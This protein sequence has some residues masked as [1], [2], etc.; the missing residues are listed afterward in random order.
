MI[1]DC[2]TLPTPLTLHADLCI[3]G[4]G[5]GG[6]M[7][8]LE[9]AQAGLKVVVLEAGSF[10]TPSGMSQLEDDMFPKLF[11]ESGGR[12]N[13]DHN[14]HIY[15][16]RGIGGSTLHNLNLIKRI[17]NPILDDWIKTRQL[18]E[19]Q[20]ED[21]D[22]LY[23]EVEQL[24]EVSDV[25]ESMIN[26]H[27][28]LLKTGNE[29]L[30][31]K[32]GFMKHNRTGCIGSGFCEVGCAYDA[33]NNACKVLVP[34]AVKAGAEFFTHCQASRV[35]HKNG[36]VTGV[37]AYVVDKDNYRPLGK[38]EVKASR[39]C[40]SAS[41]T[42]TAAI[43]KRSRLKYPK[44]SVGETLRIHPAVIV[45]GEYDQPVRA[46]EG[47]PQ[48]Y[49]CTEFL[50]FENAASGEHNKGNKANRLWIVNAF[51]HPMG[52]ST[53][54]PGHGIAHA[55]LMARYDHMAV[56]TAMLHDHSK[57]V[58]KPVKDL[59]LKIDYKL[60]HE[61]QEELHFGL[62]ACARLI[63]A[64]G[65]KRAIISTDP[66]IE[67]K[68]E[69]ELDKIDAISISKKAVDIAAVHP[70]GSVPMGDDP[71]VAAVDSNGHFHHLDGLWIADGSLFPTS[72]GVPPQLSIYSIGL[73]V[74]R[75]IVQ[76]G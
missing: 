44:N 2:T 12:T 13:T 57:G 48:A 26:L 20:H 61:D 62:K 35:V 21:W 5:A 8:A 9:A 14:I 53:L 23:S 70:M 43:I 74:G 15:Q 56:F 46:W 54:L 47:I 69:R 52:T 18:K 73:H 50:D 34:G 68:S 60:N 45:A 3:I 27:N 7:V 29:N 6:S 63:L 32:G 72:I 40:L 55:E 67:I 28:K 11:W 24:L 36:K 37:E 76:F 64:S 65:A 59:G 31:W 1:F 42:G 17:P 66:I 22:R 51:A 10:L 58:V 30:G 25:P 75:K 71:L 41:A 16:G 38:V 49:E 19:L 39:V 4:S 33:K